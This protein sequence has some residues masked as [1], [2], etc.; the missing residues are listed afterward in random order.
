DRLPKKLAAV[1][2]ISALLYSAAM[3]AD[4]VRLDRD[5]RDFVAGIPAVP[6]G[7]RLLPLLFNHKGASDNTRSLLH[8]WGFYVTEKHTSAP[9]LF[10]HSRSFPVMYSAPP[11]IRF[12]HLVLESFATNM[13][14]SDA[15]C[16]SIAP[17]IA[18]D[19]QGEY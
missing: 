3:G 2:G 18:N 4:F 13:A 14:K 10:A 17:I 5:R 12:N 1:L 11:P 15:I 7:A 16:Q 8:A 19:C 6:E 9:L